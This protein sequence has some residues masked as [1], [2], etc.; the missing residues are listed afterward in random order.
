MTKPISKTEAIKRIKAL[1]GMTARSQDGEIRVTYTL[2][3]INERFPELTTRAAWIAKA[4]AVACYDAD[5]QAAIDNAV[6]LANTLTPFEECTVTKAEA[7]DASAAFCEAIAWTEINADLIQE[8]ETLDDMERADFCLS[9]PFEAQKALCDISKRLPRTV[10]AFIDRHGAA[11]F[12][13]DL[14][15]S[16]QGHGA[17]FWDRGGLPQASL[18]ALHDAAC[19]HIKEGASVFLNRHGFLQVEGLK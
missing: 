6:A 10:R 19:L 12:G 3:E 9:V 15:L 8:E 16:S 7:R 13:H 17:G 5:P 1:P 18:D 2:E 4:E 14:W 11:Q